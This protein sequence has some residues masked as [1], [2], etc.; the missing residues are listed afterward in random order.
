MS[1]SA[2]VHLLLYANGE[3]V[4]RFGNGIF[5]WFRFRSPAEAK[6]FQGDVEKWRPFLRPVADLD[7]LRQ[8][9]CQDSD[10]NSIVSRTADLFGI[11]LELFQVGYSIFDEQV[12]IKYND[13][14]SADA[15]SVGAFDEFHL[16]VAP[17]TEE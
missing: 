3:L 14:I 9:W 1:D 16:L 11:Q 7:T 5:P 15:L 10:A 6:L 13:W 2:I 8:V 4:D 12:E 17:A